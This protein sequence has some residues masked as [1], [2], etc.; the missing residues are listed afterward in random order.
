[1]KKL[2]YLHLKDFLK[3]ECELYLQQLLTPSQR[4][5]IVAYRTSNHRLAIET[6]W[7]TTIPI[8]RDIRLCHF[9]SYNA[10][11]HEAHCVLQC[12]L[13]NP[14]RDKF[15]SLFENVVSGSFKSFF[16]LDHQVDINLHLME[17]IGATAFC[18]SR[19]LTSLKLSWCIFSPIG[20]FCFPD[21]KMNF[22]SL[23]NLCQLNEMDTCMHLLSCCAN[24][25][26][27]KPHT[28]RHN[29]AIHAIA[30][31]YWHTPPL[32]LTH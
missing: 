15:Q 29:E 17:A 5:I 11:E 7:W 20:L 22:I 12:P 26:I 18:H 27:N 19:E 23:C 1:M 3:Y 4:K 10:I 9:C 30:E 16:Q 31:P 24:K 21:F 32:A 28:D 8:S 6:G 14:I 2:D 25:Y 13:Y